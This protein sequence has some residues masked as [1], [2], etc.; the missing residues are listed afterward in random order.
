MGLFSRKKER[1][2][3]H[4]EKFNLPQFHDEFPKYESSVSQDDFSTIKSAIKPNDEKPP[5]PRKMTFA[6][7]PLKEGLKVNMQDIARKPYIE[8]SSYNI[9]EQNNPYASTPY[10]EE[11]SYSEQSDFNDVRKQEK[12]LFIKIDR[13]KESMERVEH[14][15]LQLDEMNKVIAKL[16]ELKSEEDK[17]INYCNSEI[18]K[19]KNNVD[20]IDKI[21]FGK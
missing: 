9:D 12:T 7:M 10:A 13:Y 15:K 2:E 3:E 5:M 19:I 6:A 11:R 14:I 21:L 18:N 16:N 17:E 4:S 8:E 20:D 1:K